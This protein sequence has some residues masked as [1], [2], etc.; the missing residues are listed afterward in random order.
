MKR[1]AVGKH[2][3]PALFQL[4]IEKNIVKKLSKIAN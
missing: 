4:A 2:Y 3:A 1:A